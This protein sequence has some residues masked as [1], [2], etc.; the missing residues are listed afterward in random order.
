MVD[1]RDVTELVTEV[2]V[3]EYDSGEKELRVRLDEE[4]GIKHNQLAVSTRNARN[5]LEEEIE[6]LFHK[7][8]EVL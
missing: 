2:T 4:A 6:K 8:K 7:A 5:R 1:R 3:E